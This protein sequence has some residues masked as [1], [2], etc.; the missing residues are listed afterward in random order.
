M[1]AKM[2]NEKNI[3]RISLINMIAIIFV[4]TVAMI[5]FIVRQTNTEFET[6]RAQLVKNFI[7]TKKTNLKS[8]VGRLLDFTKFNTVQTR[9]AIKENMKDRV[10]E[11]VSLAISY[12]KKFHNKFTDKEIDRNLIDF[13]KLY[14]WDEGKGYLYILDKKGNVI[15]HPKYKSGTNLLKLKTPFGTMPVQTEIVTAFEKGGGFVENMMPKEAD[16]TEFVQRISYVKPAGIHDWYIGSS[17]NEDFI[18]DVIKEKV[19]HR[20]D[21][22]NFDNDGHYFIINTDGRGVSIPGNKDLNGKDLTEISDSSGVFY[23]KNLLSYALQKNDLF[24]FHKEKYKDWD[25][26]NQVIS[27]CRI[28]EQ[29]NWLMCGTV[30]MNDL[31][32]LINARNEALKKKITDNKQYALVL[33]IIAAIVASGVSYVFSVNIQKIFSR[34]KHDIENRN[35]ELEELNIELTNQLYTDHLTGLPNR[36]KLVNDLN[37]VD[38]PI[39]IML[40]IDS[41][42]KIN[43]TYGFII[44]DFVL[45]DVGE[46]ISSFDNKYDMKTYKF[47]GNEYAILIDSD[48]EGNTLKTL[49][50]ELTE[51]LDFNVKYEELEIEID[52]SVTAGVSAEKGN[53]FEKAGMALR[54]ADKKKLPYTIY[55]SSIDIVD[56]YENDIRWTKI[57][58]RAL[59][60]NTLVPYFQPIANSQT[61]EVEKFECLLRLIDHDEVITPFQFL[62]IIKK[63]KLYQHITRRIITKSFEMFTSNDFMFSINLSI[64]DVMD[65]STSKFILD[66]LKTSGIANRVIFELL[67]SEG[68]ES[69]EVVNDFIKEIKKT[70]AMVA[71]DDFG[72]GYSNFV[73]L[74]ELQVDIIKIDGSL[75]KNIDKDTQAQIIVGTII[76]FAN[77]LNIKTVAEFVHSESVK[78]KVIEM[79]IDY[80]QGYHIGQPTAN[81]DSYVI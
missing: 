28:Y 48:I 43:E 76:K 57:V 13:F 63:T 64:E 77:Q 22:V 25:K 21:T 20:I 16:S 36:N 7:E 69:F 65:E 60:E 67:E 31:T 4:L 74:S 52:I 33:F 80:I 38:S 46:R 55:D 11:A 41:F 9:N 71:I 12:N 61:G 56:E 54:H 73:Y 42:K 51:Y 49:V 39:L 81:I 32:P 10:N 15:Y 35:K 45:I 68:I 58:K 78:L 23:Y 6:E 2:F 1:F 29:W 72:S 34:Y 5:A 66:L 79:G 24:V 26:T 14:S 70:G 53:I 19:T 47:H 27:Y 62:D 44:G 40:N 59:N 50:H 37:T 17:F 30:A 18:S 75:I 3:G 8:E